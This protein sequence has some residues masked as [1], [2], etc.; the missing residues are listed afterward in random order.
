MIGEDGVE[1]VDL[2]AEDVVQVVKVV[3]VLGH[4]VLQPVEA[5]MAA[6]SM[7]LELVESKVG[8]WRVSLS[9]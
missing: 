9:M 4:E 1:S 6:D 7:R 3:E 5:P 2:E 8:R